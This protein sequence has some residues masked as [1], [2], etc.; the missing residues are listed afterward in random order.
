M[1]KSRCSFSIKCGSGSYFS[2]LIRIRNRIL[3]LMKV[4]KVMRISGQWY[5]DPPGL[6]CEPP[7]SIVSIIGPPRLQLVSLKLLN[8]DCNVGSA[9]SFLCGSGSTFQNN[10]NPDPEP[11]KCSHE[12]SAFNNVICSGGFVTVFVSRFNYLKPSGQ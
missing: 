2:L 8:C 4:M 9:F 6:Y 3:L 11:C 12:H 1:K 10:A 7:A 5:S